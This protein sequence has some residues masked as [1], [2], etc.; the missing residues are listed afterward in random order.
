MSV[1]LEADA[2]AWS[3]EAS[4]KLRRLACESSMMVEARSASE[5]L[6]SFDS[7]FANA[8]AALKGVTDA[9]MSESW[10]LKMG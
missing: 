3:A 10:L 7:K 6:Q 1:W 2:R 8:I 9:A 4:G 5:L